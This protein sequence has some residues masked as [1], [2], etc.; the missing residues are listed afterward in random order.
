LREFVAKKQIAN[1]APDLANSAYWTSSWRLHC[2][3]THRRF[4]FRGPG[5][6]RA[7]RGKRR[8]SISSARAG[9]AAPRTEIAASDRIYDP[10]ERVRSG[11]RV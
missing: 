11:T 7:A 2:Q 3:W 9:S 5:W 4:Q 8:N 1:S 6:H 10:S